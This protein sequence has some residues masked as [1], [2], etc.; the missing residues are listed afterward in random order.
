[1]SKTNKDDK[2]TKMSQKRDEDGKM[3][4]TIND[5]EKDT[6]ISKPRKIGDDDS[7]MSE[8]S[9]KEDD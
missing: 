3:I 9:K 5:A 2:D 4:E 8:T 1:M 6:V 7:K